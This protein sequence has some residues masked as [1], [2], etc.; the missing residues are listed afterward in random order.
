MN[1]GDHVPDFEL[2]DQHGEPRKLSE[3][4]ADGPLVLFFYPLASSGGCTKEACHF[5]NLESEFKAAGAS[6]AGIS[7]DSTAKQLKF[8]TENHFSYPLLSDAKGE[9]AEQFGVRRHLL[10]KTLPSKRATFIIDSSLTL[11]F[12]VTSETN[13]DV[14]ADTALKAL[15]DNASAW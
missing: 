10:S 13:M 3:L 11:R 5:R 12:Q 2:L 4:A 9:V 6:I 1:I 15:H 14:H 8:A 7:N